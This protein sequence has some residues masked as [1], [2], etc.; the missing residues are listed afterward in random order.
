MT[1]RVVRYLRNNVIG[2]VAIF[3]ALAAGAYAAGLPTD[4]VRSKQIKAGA[5]KNADLAENAV[6]SPKVAN[7][8]LLSEDFAAGQ[9]LRGPEGPQ[10]VQGERGLQGL[11][12]NNGAQGQPGPTFVSVASAQDPV[13]VPDAFVLIQNFTTPTSGKLLAVL[14]NSGITVTCSVGDPTIGLYI[15]RVAVPETKRFLV[16]G[17]AESIDVFGTTAVLPAAAH[18]LEVGVDCAT[19]AFNSAS[20]SLDGSE[21][22]QL[23]GG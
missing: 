11:S 20:T 3:I 14:T 5:V 6:T 15:D 18:K 2:L 8:S 22:V 1:G 12:G 7:G 16:N 23:F 17:V 4:S 9:L 19:G 21:G 13:A 10:G